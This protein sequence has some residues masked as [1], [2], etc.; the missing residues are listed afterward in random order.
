MK[1]LIRYAILGLLSSSAYGATVVASGPLVCTRDYNLWGEASRCACPTP[2][3][4]DRRIGRCIQ[5]ELEPISIA[6]EIQ[7]PVSAIG[8]ETTGIVLQASELERYELVLP[9]YLRDQMQ[10]GQVQGISYEVQGDYLVVPGVE[11]GDR[12]T[13]IVNSLRP[14]L[15]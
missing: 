8:G 12:P 7:S 5:G 14:I 15:E 13:I 1:Y 9:R 10:E 2:T 11:T 6:G 4:Y 3:D